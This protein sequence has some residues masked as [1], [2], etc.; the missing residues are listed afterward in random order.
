MPP[1]LIE[2]SSS[3]DSLET[4]REVNR[5]LRAALVRLRP[6]RK[7]CAN[8]KPEDFSSMLAELMRASAC[9]RQ[10]RAHQATVADFQKETAEYHKNLEELRRF[11]P[12]LHLRLLAERSRLETAR[13]H[14]AAAAAWAKARE[15]TL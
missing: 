8:V 11:L 15:K 12:N 14:V 9:L 4:L 10:P 5:N 13:S 2:Q 6:E 1:G 7:H 3:P